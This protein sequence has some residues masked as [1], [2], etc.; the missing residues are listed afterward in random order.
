[1]TE[2]E[3][4]FGKMLEKNYPEVVFIELE[5]QKL[6]GTWGIKFQTPEG[7]YLFGA[8]VTKG[9]TKKELFE[10]LKPFKKQKGDKK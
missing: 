6:W 5:F 7:K 10:L 2:K 3:E 9:L 4:K 8:C 1:M